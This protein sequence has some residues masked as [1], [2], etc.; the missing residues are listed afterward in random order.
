MQSGQAEK[1]LVYGLEY[2]RSTLAVEAEKLAIPSFFAHVSQ[3]RA[4]SKAIETMILCGSRARARVWQSGHTE[5]ILTVR[6][7]PQM[8]YGM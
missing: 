1:F 8:V 6:P 2:Y 3:R 5:K 7:S 4:K